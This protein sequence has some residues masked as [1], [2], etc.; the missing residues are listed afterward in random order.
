MYISGALESVAEVQAKI[1]NEIIV[2]KADVFWQV[3]ILAFAPD[4]KTEA[5]LVR[6]RNPPPQHS[7]G[8]FAQDFK[9]PAI[10][11]SVKKI[12][13]TIDKIYNL[14]YNIN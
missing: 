4:G 13:I 11:H 3:A 1:K 12:H 8:G 5:I 6:R 2:C 9:L 10:G 14:L 7:D